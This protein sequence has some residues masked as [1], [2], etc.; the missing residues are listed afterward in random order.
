MSERDITNI[1]HEL[2]DCYIL[3][4]DSGASVDSI[5]DMK[6]DGGHGLDIKNDVMNKIELDP[7]P[8]FICMHHPII[9]S[10]SDIYS[11]RQ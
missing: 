7:K 11:G 6:G 8:V 1:L 5:A 3:G 9:A 4:L 10:R 2:D